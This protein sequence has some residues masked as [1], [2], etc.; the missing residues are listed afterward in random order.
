MF[1]LIHDLLAPG[2]TKD[3]YIRDEYTTYCA[4]HFKGE[5]LYRPVLV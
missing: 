1:E 4:V 5:Y 2:L 3:T